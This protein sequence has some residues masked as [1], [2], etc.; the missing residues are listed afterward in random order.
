[1]T[2]SLLLEP[3]RI[4]TLQLK[5]RIL[6][7][8]MHLGIEGRREALP[9]LISFYRER[10]SG[11]AALMMT[12][13]V[14]VLPEGGGSG[15][16][17]LTEPDHRKQLEELAAAVRQSGGR[18][19]LQL[20]HRGRYA[21]SKETGLM[22]WAPSPIASR[23]TKEVPA[24]M[25]GSDI[26]RL[27]DA[28]RDG[29]AFAVDAGFAAIE[30][31]G[32]EG[33]L[34]NEFVSPLTNRRSDEYGQD[35]EGRMKLCLDIIGDIRGRIGDE[36]PVVYRISG[37]DYMEGSTT[38]EETLEFARRLERCGVDAL[39][40]GIGW[41]ESAIPTVGAIVPPGAFA[42][43]AA[44]IR[45][46]VSIP[47]IGA[48]RI[49]TPEVAERLLLRGD[50]DFVA[51]ARPW[52]A[53]PAFAR[54]IA[55][56]DLEGLNACISCNQLCLD[57]TLGHPPKPV[58]CLVNPRTGHEA[59]IVPPPAEIRR[60][61]VVGGGVAGLQAAL[62]SAER[63]HRVTLFEETDRL[64][65]QFLLASRI[66]G[67]G[68]FRE[69]IRYF[70]V[71]L[72]RLGVDIRMGTAPTPRMLEAFD[73][74]ILASGV[75]PFV[76]DT[77][78]GADL[79]HVC[80]YAELLAG[81]RPFGK[82]IAVVGGG[83]IGSDVAHY[84][85]E[86]ASLQPEEAAFFAERGFEAPAPAAP[87]ITLVSR[88]EKAAKGVGPTSR[89]VLLGELKRRGVRVLK[90]YRCTAITAEGIWVDNGEEQLFVEA[91]QVVLCMGQRS[92]LAPDDS[93]FA[94][95]ALDAVGGAADPAELNAAR[96]IRQAYEAAVKL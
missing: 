50:L 4:G 9:Q 6:M 83:G 94:H 43:V 61:A 77:L 30:I 27:R 79:P 86:R 78:E 59:E 32:S 63:G 37:D 85:A 91:D 49:H 28:F 69:T 57:H 62:T 7:G 95:E 58:G 25:T 15:M 18:L 12:G 68:Q 73:H 42:S 64:G 93:S 45:G 74:V 24:E 26:K 11:G 67:K 10:A 72:Q 17:C 14:A 40:V 82:K 16:F 41:H 36:F 56:G 29:A 5:H 31:M 19:A 34:L 23:L 3:G 52:L 13:N 53:D 70:R 8:A 84:L 92:N 66:P 90:G 35:S 96:A 44:S 21:S 51:P 81:T 88:S 76:P 22:P 80:T 87:E 33:Y 20:S 1:M 39:N 54:K 47:V 65:G 89:W 46:V 60:I 71:M 2:R 38:R 48:N 75:R 55:E